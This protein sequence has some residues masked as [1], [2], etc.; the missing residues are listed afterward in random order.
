[1]V[2]FSILITFTFS[3]KLTKFQQAKFIMKSFFLSAHSITF[4]GL[5]HHIAQSNSKTLYS[6]CPSRAFLLG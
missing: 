4:R 5:D 2:F 3:L 1:M 6:I